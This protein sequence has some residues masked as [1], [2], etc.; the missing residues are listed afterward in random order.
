MVCDEIDYNKSPRKI[1]QSSKNL[2]KVL[3]KANTIQMNKTVFAISNGKKSEKCLREI[4]GSKMSLDLNSPM[5]SYNI[6][7][8]E[9]DLKIYKRSL[10]LKKAKLE[11]KDSR[12][13]GIKPDDEE[14]AKLKR[15]F[16]PKQVV[17]Q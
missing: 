5:V 6:D 9:E 2:R 17:E 13:Y 10:T 12:I 4:L 1:I 15:E 8:K 14:V 16:Y 11:K 3:I 7:D